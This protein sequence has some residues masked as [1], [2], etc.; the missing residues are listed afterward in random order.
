VVKE[1]TT[2][3][4]AL[5][6]HPDLVHAGRGFA[7]ELLV[8]EVRIEQLDGETVRVIEAGPERMKHSPSV[9]RSSG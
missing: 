5:D 3:A 8:E 7:V 6:A 2:K 1:R 4:I 9:T